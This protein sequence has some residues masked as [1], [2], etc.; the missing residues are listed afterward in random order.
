MKSKNSK[1][2]YVSAAVLAAGAVAGV[3]TQ[4]AHAAEVQK[5]AN[6]NAAQKTI[7]QNQIGRASCRER[8]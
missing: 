4:N 3:N 1:L 6:K 5:Q 7:D 2:M 8:V